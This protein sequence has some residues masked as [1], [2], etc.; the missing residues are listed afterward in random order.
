VS[1][2][3]DRPIIMLG[4]DADTLTDY[5]CAFQTFQINERRN[6]VV[7]APTPSN[8]T[9]EEKAGAGQA[10]VSVVFLSDYVTSSGLW[11]EM[12]NAQATR[13]AELYFEYTPADDTVSA[14][15]PKRTGYIVVT[16]LDTGAPAFEAR[17]Q[18]KTFPARDISQP[19]TVA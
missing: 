16:D 8:P 10:S 2:V 19:I 4:P 5:S 7:K 6:T 18:A 3:Q 13:T 15:N 17:R 14:T 12:L 11:Q 9:F 1:L